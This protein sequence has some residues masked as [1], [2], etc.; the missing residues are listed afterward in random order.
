MSYSFRA[1]ARSKDECGPSCARCRLPR[2]ISLNERSKTGRCGLLG[3]T[4]GGFSRAVS[5]MVIGAVGIVGG[6]A[7][8]MAYE[9][10]QYTYDG[11]GRIAKV[12]HSGAINQGASTTYQYD[13]ADNRSNVAMVTSWT[14]QAFRTGDFNGDGKADILLRQF[15]SGIITDWFSNASGGWTSNGATFAAAVSAVWKVVA[16]GDVNGDGK[17]DIIWRAD[18]GDLAVWT[19]DSTGFCSG[20]WS[21]SAPPA[22]KI[23]GVGDFNGD[24]RCDILWRNDN[25]AVT[26]WLG[27]TDASFVDNSA[28]AGNSVGNDWHIVGTG[29]FNGDGRTD[30]LWRND[31][32][33]VTDWLA[34]STG[35]FYGNSAVSYVVDSQWK[36]V[37]VGDFNGDHRSDILFRNVNGSMT[38]WQGTPTGDFFQTNYNFIVDTSWR[39]ALVG[40]FNAPTDLSDDLLWRDRAGNLLQWLGTSN[41]TF[42]T[43]SNASNYVDPAWNLEPE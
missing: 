9:T 39:I 7:P 25:G 20:V 8:L 12:S 36:V 18:N 28:N 34:T 5:F 31:N 17:S 4:P 23:A 29:D 32:G 37:A 2:N 24:G 16:V 42:A 35:G 10:I 41:G 21:A 43:N 38:E 26:E 1:S 22:W 3:R 40:N 14:S 30:V 27:Q 33:Q 19:C 11:L 13:K 15:G 6:A